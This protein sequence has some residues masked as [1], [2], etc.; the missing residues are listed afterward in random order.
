MDTRL[1]YEASKHLIR[2]VEWNKATESEW[3]FCGLGEDFTTDYIQSYLNNHLKDSLLYVAAGRNNSIKICKEE[4]LNIIL[5]L[6]GQDFL[7]WTSDFKYA[8]EFNNIGVFRV[9]KTQAN[10]GLTQVASR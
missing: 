3:I 8:I 7:L 5:K 9:G 4:A 2:H 6:Q 1:I 10:K